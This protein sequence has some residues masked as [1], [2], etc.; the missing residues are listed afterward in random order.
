MCGGISNIEQGMP[1]TQVKRIALLFFANKQINRFTD[2]QE[3]MIDNFNN[4]RGQDGFNFKFNPQACEY[5]GGRCCYGESGYI[6]VSNAEQKRIAEHLNIRLEKFVSDYLRKE[7]GKYT[8]KDI[9]FD[10]YYSC[11]FFDREERR[12]SIYPARPKQ[13]RTY[14]FWE[15]YKD[16]PEPLFDECPGIYTL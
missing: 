16:N 10:N 5:C 13:C 3:F 4:K 8:I 12:C 15:I 1:N 11:L 2:E 7:N 14:P 9:K 6:W